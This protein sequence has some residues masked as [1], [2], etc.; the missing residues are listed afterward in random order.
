VR[1]KVFTAVGICITI[2]NIIYYIFVMINIYY[3]YI[4]LKDR[5]IRI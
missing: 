4:P 1:F 5:N 2:I 3:H